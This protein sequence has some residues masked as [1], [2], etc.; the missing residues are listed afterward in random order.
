MGNYQRGRAP[1]DDPESHG[2]IY[3]NAFL[4]LAVFSAVA[5]TTHVAPLT[6]RAHSDHMGYMTGK[7]PTERFF[8]MRISKNDNFVERVDKLR[9]LQRPIPSRAEMLRRLVEREWRKHKGK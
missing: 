8:H 6:T 7:T 9:T 3:M 4:S 2:L 5:L 1:I